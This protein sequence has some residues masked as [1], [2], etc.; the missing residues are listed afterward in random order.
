MIQLFQYRLVFLK[1]NKVVEVLRIQL[2]LSTI[3]KT[4]NK[5]V[6][7]NVFWYVRVCIFWKFIQ[8][9]IHWDKTQI[10]F[11]KNKR[12]KQGSTDLIF[13]CTDFRARKMVLRAQS[14]WALILNWH[15][16]PSIFWYQL[17]LKNIRRG[18]AQQKGFSHFNWTSTG[19]LRIDQSRKLG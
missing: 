19:G 4:G 3:L 14:L 13:A 2:K 12:Y 8:Y 18:Y 17:T 16:F 5:S 6:W 15:C 9:T 11:G 7:S 10:S 1:Y